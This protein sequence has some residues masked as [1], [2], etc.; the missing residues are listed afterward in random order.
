MT[1]EDEYFETFSREVPSIYL[2]R[3]DQEAVAEEIVN[4]IISG[5][6]LQESAAERDPNKNI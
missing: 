3:E 4:A 5:V 2:F 1:L 6:P